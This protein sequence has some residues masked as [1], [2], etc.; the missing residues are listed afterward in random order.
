VGR[1]LLLGLENLLSTVSLLRTTSSASE[2]S[3][4]RLDG[5]AGLLL[6]LGLSLGLGSVRRPWRAVAFDAHLQHHVS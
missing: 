4:V 2:D 3:P 6:V 5:S 1:G